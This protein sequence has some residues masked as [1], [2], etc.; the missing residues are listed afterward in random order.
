MFGFYLKKLVG[1]M[2]MP[3]PLTLVGIVVG[4]ALLNKRP[5]LGKGLIGA[6]ALLLFLTSWMPTAKIFIEPFEHEYRPFNVQTTPV[7]AIVILG[8]C[9]HASTDVPPFALLC[10]TSLYRLLEG[11]RIAKANPNAL[12]YTSGFDVEGE[13]THAQVMARLAQSLGIEP[14]R[15]RLSNGN[16]DTEDE[17]IA[18]KSILKNTRFALVTEATHMPRAMRLFHRHGLSPLAAP[19][20]K[21]HG[22]GADWYAGAGPQYLSHQAFYEALGRAWLWLKGYD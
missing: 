3:I 11:V 2:L 9:H 10:A 8:G 1:M 13:L 7:D 4:L 14:S 5:K 16:H 15:I 19:A 17:A 18:L 22:E 12:L 6:S 21:I 20:F